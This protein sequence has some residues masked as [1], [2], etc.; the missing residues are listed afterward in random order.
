MGVILVVDDEAGQRETLAGVL[1]DRGHTVLEAADGA[2]AL[3]LLRRESIDLLLTDMRMPGLSGHELLI[4]CRELKPDVP[5]VVMTAYGTVDVAVAAMKSGAADFLTKP[6]DLDQLEIVVDR[7]LATRELVRENRALR[8]RLEESIG[9]FRLLGGSEALRDVLLRAGRTAE[10]DATALILGESGTGKELL[11]RS[12]HDLGKRSAGPFVAVN[13]SALPETLL[14]SELFGHVRGAFTGA[15]RDRI[16]RVEAARGGTLFLDEIGDLSPA[17]QVKLLRFLQDQ[18][19]TPVGDVRPRRG[20]VRVLAATNRDLPAAIADGSFRE[21][22]FYRLNVV[23][24]VLPPLR[25]RREDIPELAAHFLEVYAR[26]YDR[27]ART[28]S[29][30]AMDCIMS[31]PFKGNVRELENAIEQTVV[32]TRGEVIHRNDLPAALCGPDRADHELP[33]ASMVRGDL[34]DFLV[35]IERKIVTETLARFHGNQSDTARHLGLTESGL[36]YKLKK[37]RDARKG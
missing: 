12:I 25:E 17:V 16:G 27:R 24:L 8:R 11:A 6:I 32:L 33:D 9:G 4:E 5:V 30:E 7:A 14:E 15:D 26:R 31:H 29:R 35:G 13:C 21:D 34:N 22:L 1:R 37:W 23:N 10:T 18:E 19:Y 3:A 20:D 2:A 36:R 28:F